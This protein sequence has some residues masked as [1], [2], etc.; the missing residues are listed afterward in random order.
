MHSADSFQTASLWR[1]TYQ[2]QQHYFRSMSKYNHQLSSKIFLPMRINCFNPKHHWPLYLLMILSNIYYK[3]NFYNWN[4]SH[5]YR[6]F[7]IIFH[8]PHNNR[9][10]RSWPFC[11]AHDERFGNGYLMY[12]VGSINIQW[13]T[14]SNLFS[15]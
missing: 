9:K 6:G 1:Y 2:D 8:V 12:G 3:K 11:L 5:I 10:K 7:V 4:F 15:I 13:N 14:I